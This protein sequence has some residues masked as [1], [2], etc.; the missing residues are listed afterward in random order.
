LRP[1]VDVV[2]DLTPMYDLEEG[3][4]IRI[5]NE[6]AN[7]LIQHLRS[8]QGHDNAAAAGHLAQQAARILANYD[9]DVA[10]VVEEVGFRQK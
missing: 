7:L 9:P 3:E 8:L 6:L 2:P 4:Y 10:E 5:I 1:V